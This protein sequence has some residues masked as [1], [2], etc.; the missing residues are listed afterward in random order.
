[1]DHCKLSDG[2]HLF[3]APTAIEFLLVRGVNGFHPFSFS[4]IVLV[5][6]GGLSSFLRAG[7][8]L[9]VPLIIWVVDEMTSL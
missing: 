8:Y 2:P 4:V 6:K 5:S 9:Y 1:M 7:S 3:P